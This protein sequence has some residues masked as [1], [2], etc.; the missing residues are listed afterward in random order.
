MTLRN[1]GSE[2]VELVLA[3]QIQ[4]R[5]PTDGRSQ[6]KRQC[7]AFNP[8]VFDFIIEAA[9]GSEVWSLRHGLPLPSMGRRLPLAPGEEVAF[10]HDWD[11]QDNDGEPVPAGTYHVRGLLPA[12]SADLETG[13]R[14]L[15][16][17]PPRR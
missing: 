1:S 12:N 2:P 4:F 8:V 14:I 9:D 7:P 11:Q 6:P 15:V 16:I 5:P 17:V 3:A 13:T 10:V